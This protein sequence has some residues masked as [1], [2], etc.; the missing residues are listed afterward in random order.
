MLMSFVRMPQT[1]PMMSAGGAVAER[2]QRRF[3]HE[4]RGD[5]PANQRA[6]CE[7]EDSS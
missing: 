7:H 2:H 4:H 5:H 3:R 6:F 1:K